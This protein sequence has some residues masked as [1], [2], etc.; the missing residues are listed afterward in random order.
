LEQ[1]ADV[2]KERRDDVADR[3]MK[4]EEH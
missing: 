3:E 1:A 2:V 4:N